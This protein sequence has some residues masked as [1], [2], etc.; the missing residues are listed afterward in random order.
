MN[1][2]DI[3]RYLPGVYQQTLE[4]E[5]GPLAALLSAME[6]LHEPVEDTIASFDAT[7]NPYRTPDRFVSYLAG[8]LDLDYLLIEG[9][10]GS[11]VLPSGVT[12]LRE[13]I[14][15]GA[16]LM[17]WR[18][19][20]RGLLAFLETATGLTGFAIEDQVTNEAGA[21][22]PFHIR[23]DIPVEAEPHRAM[24]DAIVR[25]ERPAHITYELSA[26][27]GTPDA[28]GDANPN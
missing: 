2:A 5:R 28:G 21:V 3:E 26:L 27:G 9:P 12:R 19:T 4:N 1:R 10:D 6:A 20:R 23:V 25:T 15:T 22:R 24:I 11:H 14:A 16:E 7:F 18:G 17:R 13:L 8:W